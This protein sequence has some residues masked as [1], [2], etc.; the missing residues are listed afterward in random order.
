MS[1][2]IAYCSY[3]AIRYVSYVSLV[4]PICPIYGAESSYQSEMDLHHW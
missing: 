1:L 4:F 2:K 3:V